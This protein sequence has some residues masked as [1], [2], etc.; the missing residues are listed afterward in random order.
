MPKG[1]T[2]LFFSP[3]TVGRTLILKAVPHRLFTIVRELHGGCPVPGQEYGSPFLME[4]LSLAQ[5]TH[6][7][8]N[9]GLLPAME[10][11]QFPPG[12]QEGFQTNWNGEAPVQVL[13]HFSTAI[14]VCFEIANLVF[15][16]RDTEQPQFPGVA[17]SMNDWLYFKIRGIPL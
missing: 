17:N 5:S 11:L 3:C 4:S 7:P 6:K 2:L 12:P 8:A 10:T 16:K 13:D 15:P 14:S 1:T 9:G